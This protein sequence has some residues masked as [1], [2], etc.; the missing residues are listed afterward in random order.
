M[1]WKLV[2]V[3]IINYLITIIIFGISI[4]NGFSFNEFISRYMVAIISIN[5]FAFI[6]YKFVFGDIKKYRDKPNIDITLPPTESDLSDIL[7][8][9][10]E[11]IGTEDDFKEINLDDL[12]K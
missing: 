11:Q 4:I 10:Y 1:K 6:L 5:V 12:T 2:S 9:S 7:K 3:F 8:E